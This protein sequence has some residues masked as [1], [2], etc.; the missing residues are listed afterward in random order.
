MDSY[1]T[2]LMDN[3]VT[4][5]RFNKTVKQVAEIQPATVLVIV[6]TNRSTCLREKLRTAIIHSQQSQQASN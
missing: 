5:G 4:D 6:P 3:Y 1:I 2:V